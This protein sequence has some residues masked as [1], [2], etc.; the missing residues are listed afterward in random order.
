[1][2]GRRHHQDRPA[3]EVFVAR[4]KPSRQAGRDPRRYL[5]RYY[6]RHPGA[7]PLSASWSLELAR[8]ALEARLADPELDPRIKKSARAW[9]GALV[10][11][12]KERKFA[13]VACSP[14]KLA[15]RTCG[16]HWPGYHEDTGRRR[17]HDFERWG[18]VSRADNRKGGL[19]GRQPWNKPTG[20][21]MM[22][23]LAPQWRPTAEPAPPALVKEAVT[24]IEASVPE[25]KVLPAPDPAEDPGRLSREI[26]SGAEVLHVAEAISLR[27]DLARGPT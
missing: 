1:M 7:V 8:P 21:A 20:Q 19:L 15:E 14:R 4:L 25:E 13:R 6:A 27:D 26:S 16:K 10:D 12:Q 17:M 3:R 24:P 5:Q 18:L 23:E 2:G 11:Q 9:F 22:I